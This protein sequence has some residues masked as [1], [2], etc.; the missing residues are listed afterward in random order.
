[1]RN[2]RPKSRQSTPMLNSLK[3]LTEW[4]ATA[5]PHFHRRNPNKAA[6][7]KSA[8]PRPGP[9]R[10][11]TLHPRPPAACPKQQFIHPRPSEAY[12]RRHFA[13][14]RP[15]EAHPRPPTAYPRQ[16]FIYPKPSEAHPRAS[17]VYPRRYFAYPRAS[18]AYPRC[19]QAP[20]PNR[21]P[22]SLRLRASS[23]PGGRG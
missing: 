19:P 11:P 9:P 14:P 12:P 7:K 15:S 5:K 6:K 3:S 18:E 16:Q 23:E 13:Y 2:Q 1:M 17:E 20:A 8:I 22:L 4:P 10:P 21:C